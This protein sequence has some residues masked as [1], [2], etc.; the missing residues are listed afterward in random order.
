M[1]TNLALC[2]VRMMAEWNHRINNVVIIPLLTCDLECEH[3]CRCSSPRRKERMDQ[4]LLREISCK[5]P[6]EICE[7]TISGGEPFLDQGF[8]RDVISYLP[9]C[10]MVYI[11]TNGMW[12]R[13]A[14]NRYEFL[15]KTLPEL[16][17]LL[18][19]Y[20]D[21]VSIDLSRDQF[22]RWQEDAMD[23][24]RLLKSDSE[25]GAYDEDADVP[26]EP[27]YDDF[28]DEDEYWLAYQDYEC[29]LDETAYIYPDMENVYLTERHDYMAKVLPIGRGKSWARYDNGDKEYCNFDG[30]DRPENQLTIWPDGRCSA[31]CDGG[32]WVGNILYQD[33]P[34]ILR[35]RRAF[36]FWMRR[37][38]GTYLN[39]G[40]GVPTST[41]ARCRRLGKEYFGHRFKEEEFN[42]GNR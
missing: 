11:A 8:L 16:K 34:E 41:C 1:I 35:Q 6:E 13:D 25:N 29:A 14:H 22:H 15:A 33:V 10:D 20:S 31:C 19:R 39:G 12:T 37:R 32:A 5:L 9:E 21:G 17:R 40:S 38:V 2:G 3:C 18:P 30:N 4:R 24:W 7:L 42:A 23:G 26:E 27:D 28:E 36:L